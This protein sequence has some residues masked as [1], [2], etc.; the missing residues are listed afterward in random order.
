MKFQSK[1]YQEDIEY[2]A[3]LDL[4]WDALKGKTIMVTG[5]SGM[6]G[7]FLIDVLLYRN[8]SFQN[9][10]TV[11][12]VS[13][14]RKK[15]EQKF[16]AYEKLDLF[17]IVEHDVSK[18]M[19]LKDQCDHIIHGASNTHPIEYA[20]DPIGT[21][22]T[23]ILGTYHL[24]EYAAKQTNC[25]MVLLSSVEIY[26]ENQTDIHR[27]SEKDCGYIDCNTVR[28]GYPESK[29]LSEAMLQAY[30]SQKDIHTVSV[31]LCRTYGP[32]VERDDSKALSQFIEKAV[33]GE[34]IVLKSQGNQFYSYIYVADAVSA[35]LYS[36]L[37]GTDGE[38]YNVADPGSDATLKELAESLATSAGTSVIFELPDVGEQKGYS[39]ATRA[40]L[41]A[42]KLKKLGWQAK[43]AIGEGLER[44]V[45]MLKGTSDFRTYG[46]G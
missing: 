19:A 17:H 15:L 24:L 35:I 42:G 9:E 23:N 32:T 22:T 37:K 3:G 21:I 14:N 16:S 44:T 1:L 25:Q 20:N 28:A 2:V 40:L 29:R 38:A 8:L 4:D 13:R 41:D 33:K 43:Y 7:T 46:K 31:R 30:R 6:I 12:A 36:M 45:D 34:D 26:G 39:T 5:A 27:F 18:E 10:I 11:L